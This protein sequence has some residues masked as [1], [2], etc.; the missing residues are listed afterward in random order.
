LPV[1]GNLPENFLLR[2][3]DCGGWATWQRA[4]CLFEPDATKL[5]GKLKSLAL[6]N[7]FDLGGVA[8]N[9]AMLNQ[10]QQGIINSWAIRWHASMFLANKLTL[11][12]GKSLVNNIG[13]DASGEHCG[14]TDVYTTKVTQSPVAIVKIPLIPSATA[15]AAYKKFYINLNSLPHRI[16]RRVKRLF[17]FL[18][19]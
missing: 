19:K 14:P 2:G 7:E 15:L 5:L 16:L 4:W 3:A 17:K 13:H 9:F 6:E 18:R 8:G 11:Y 12:P 1:K 10:Q